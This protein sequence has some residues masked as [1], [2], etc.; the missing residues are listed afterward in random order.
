MASP[1]E[2]AEHAHD[3][4]VATSRIDALLRSIT[5]AGALKTERVT[6]PGTSMTVE[7]VRPTDINRLLDQ[8][9]ADPEQN[10]PYWAEVWPSGIALAAAIAQRPDL[11]A[12]HRVIE[13]GCGIG[14]TAAAAIAAGARL[15]ATDYAAEALTLTCVTTLLHTNR[16]PDATRQMNWRALSRSMRTSG[17]R[18]PVVLAA[19]VLYERRDIEPLIETVNALLAT[20]GLLWLAEPERNPASAFL[21]RLDALGW[22]RETTAWH[23]PWPDPKDADVIVRT[24]LISRPT[25][26]ST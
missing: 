4:D 2:P 20:N 25:E 23:G 6:L 8:A 5:H 11:V 14:I 10:L 26:T 22:R 16:E 9:A 19:D 3:E 18:F 15:T 21:E 7:V 13:L 17:E 12:G 1:S 24:H